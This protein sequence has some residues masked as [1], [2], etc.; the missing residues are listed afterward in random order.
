MFA[1]GILRVQA[2]TIT[3]HK[4]DGTTLEYHCSEVDSIVNYA[5]V[6]E[7]E[8]HQAVDL[9]LSVLWATCNLGATQYT[10]EGNKYAWGE[11]VSKE[12]GTKDNYW[13][14]DAESK[15]YKD[16]GENISGT[17]YDAARQEWGGDWRMPTK[18]EMEELVNECTWSRVQI[19]G[20]TYFRVTGPNKNNIT[21]PAPSYNVYGSGS[22]QRTKYSGAYWSS[23]I[24]DDLNSYSY[25]LSIY[26]YYNLFGTCNSSSYE[27]SFYG[28]S[29]QCLIRPVKNK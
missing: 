29:S 5:T 24:D 7:T 8:E 4:V 18:E 1:V 25:Y 12:N 10:H 17:I 2:Q 22:D 20:K 21:L 9:G 6:P 28:K 14:Y 23:S 3:I 16:I 11:T 27:I 15:T 13:F 26:A 19:G